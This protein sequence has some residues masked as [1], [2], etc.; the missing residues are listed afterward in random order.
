MSKKQSYVTAWIEIKGERFEILVKPDLA[1]RL[2]EGEKISLNEVLWTDIIFKDS[3][4]GLKASPEALRKAFGTEDPKVIAEKILKEGEIQLTEEERRK[5]LEAKKKKI[6]AFIAR[7]A[8]DPKTKLPIPESRIEALMEEL[9]I[10]VDLYR[11]VE[12]QAL[13]IVSKLSRA[14]PIKI[15][16]ALLE[17]EIPPDVAN[18]AVSEVK[19]LGQVKKLEWLN[20]GSVKVELEIPA[21]LQLEVINKIQSV[22]KGR[23]SVNV[24]EVV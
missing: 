8:I 13:E 15:A 1:F 10:G 23:A 16:R 3:R 20:D 14:I 24:K 4:K 21:G 5:I 11:D 7:N 22:A 6:V 19:R 17:V 2:R 18:R 9:G 12:S